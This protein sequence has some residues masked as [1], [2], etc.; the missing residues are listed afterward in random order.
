[1]NASKPEK[2]LLVGG[3]NNGNNRNQNK[4][5]H[6]N[7]NNNNKINEMSEFLSTRPKREYIIDPEKTKKFIEACK[8]G[9][10]EQVDELM[11]QKINLNEKDVNGWTGLMKACLNEH[12]EIVSLLM[13]H[14]SCDL[15]VKN[16]AGSTALIYACQK[17]H[18][19]ICELLIL[20]RA[21]HRI[22]N[23]D[24]DDALYFAQNGFGWRKEEDREAVVQLLVTLG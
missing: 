1:M 2:D 15:D 21:N 23:K 8:N 16:N 4:N 3:S 17:G 13:T 22:Q 14:K 10:K 19:E 9:D 11:K 5:N 12:K 7:N 24:G 20:N 6:N 18:K